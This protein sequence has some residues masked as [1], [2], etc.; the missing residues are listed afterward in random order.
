MAL[1]LAVLQPQQNAAP[2]QTCPQCGATSA[3]FANA[4]RMGCPE[5]YKTFA[6]QLDA[7]LPKLQ[8]G[9]RHH[10]KTPTGKTLKNAVSEALDAARKN[11]RTAIDSEAYEDA[12]RLR[13]E[14]RQLEEV[15]AVR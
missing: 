13:D 3:D 10:G 8:P 4:H 5:C 14:I 12:A 11:M 6:D 9:P 2:V 1:A 7:L 15:L